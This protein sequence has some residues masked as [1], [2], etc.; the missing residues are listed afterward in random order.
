MSNGPCS[1][2]KL[3]HSGWRSMTAASIASNDFSTWTWRN[4]SRSSPRNEQCNCWDCWQMTCGPKSRPERVLF[5][6]CATRS[7]TSSTM[8]T[9]RQWNSRAIC[10]NGSRDSG[11]TFVASTTVSLPAASRL[12]AMNC[13]SSKASFVAAWLFSSS[14]TMARQSSDDR[15]S[16]G[17]KCFRANVLLPEPDTPM[18]T[19]MESS[20]MVSFIRRHAS[21]STRDFK[22]PMATASV[23]ALSG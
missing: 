5:R 1:C 2:F 20:G 12:R 8:A 22:S 4:P 14:D 7:G 11:C 10:T 23:H 9:G 18:R 21:F 19:T 3:F 6:S 13:S 15:I 16:V 17:L